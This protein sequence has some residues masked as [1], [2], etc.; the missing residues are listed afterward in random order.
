LTG[1]VSGLAFA[2][3]TTATTNT[4][5]QYFTPVASAA[6]TTDYMW[7]GVSQTDNGPAA[8]A[9]V[10]LN[11]TWGPYISIWGSNVN[12]ADPAGSTATTEID[13]AGGIKKT[14]DQLTA[15]I[16]VMRYTYPETHGLDF[17]EVYGKLSY[18]FVQN[19]SIGVSVNSS[20]NV[21]NT[22][23]TGTY[24]AANTSLGVPSAWLAGLTGTSVVAQLGRYVFNSPAS[25]GIYSDR[26]YTDW[27]AGLSQAYKAF[28]GSV[29][30]ISTNGGFMVGNLDDH[31]VVG[32]ISASI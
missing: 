26:D 9:S 1:L 25:G 7:R 5:D 19:C 16:G 4:F 11:S 32:T 14:F 20:T 3:D 15:D 23:E 21:F 27:G 6:L 2:D 12:F 8:Q 29:M 17:N 31:R 13:Y 18:A 24:Y 28:T 10:G 30:Y 22:H